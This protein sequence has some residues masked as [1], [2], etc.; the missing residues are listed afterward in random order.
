MLLDYTQRGDVLSLSYWG[1]DGMTHIKDIRLGSEELFNWKVC[2]ENDPEKDPVYRCWDGSPVKRTDYPRKTKDRLGNDK[3]LLPRLSPFRLAEIIDDLPKDM[4]DEIFSYNIPR[5]IFVDIETAVEGEF[6]KPEEARQPITCI[7]FATQKKKVYVYAV[8]PLSAIEILG[9]QDRIDKHTESLGVHFDFVFKKFQDETSMLKYFLTRN[10]PC[11]PLMSGWN[12]ID[13]DWT[14]MYNRACKLGLEPKGAS[15]VG[16]L[17]GEKKIPLHVGVVDYMEC[18]KKWDTNVEQKENYKLDQAGHDVLGMRKVHYSGNLQDLYEENFPEYI[19]YNAIDCILVERLHDKLGVS[20]IG[21]TLAYIAHAQASRM[22][23]PVALTES[24]MARDYYKVKR[25]LPPKERSETNKKKYQGAYVKEPRVGYHRFCICNDFASLYPNIIRMLNLSPETFVTKVDEHD[26]EAKKYWLDKGYIVSESGCV[27][28]KEPGI[29]AT[30]VGRVYN[31]RKEYKKTSYVASMKS[32][33]LKE[34]AEDLSMDDAALLHAARTIMGDGSLEIKGDVRGWMMEESARQEAE[35]IKFHNWEQ[36]T[37]IFINS[38]YGGFGNAFMYFFNVDLAECITK[39]GKSAILYAEKSINKYFLEW[40]HK[41]RKTHEAMGITV[42]G[43]VVNDVTVY[44]D[45][46][47]VYSQLDE[48]ISTT[49]WGMGPDD[50]NWRVKF[51]KPGDADWRY[52]YF[53][54]KKSREYVIEYL[55]LDSDEIA[56]YELERVEGTPK[57]FALLLDEVFLAKY[58]EHIFDKYVQKYNGYNY[59]NFELESYADSGIWLAKKKYMQNIR[60]LD[61]IKRHESYDN[62]SK[63]KSKGVELIQAS[64]P[65][66]VRKSLNYLVKWIFGHDNFKMKDLIIEVKRIKREYMVADI[67]EIC[68]NKKCSNYWEYVMSDSKVLEMKSGTPIYVKGLALYNYLLN[69]S[70]Y[71]SKYGRLKDGMM[72]KFYHCDYE[73]CEMFAFEPGMYPVEFAP[74]VNREVMFRKTILDPL[75]RILD[76]IPNA[77]HLEPDLMLVSKLF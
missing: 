3:V 42:T 24:I 19:F 5:H 43:K 18:Y 20:T 30:L 57:D 29:L 22:F 14:Y 68:W 60:W 12:F 51:K 28:S 34:A 72:C 25:V 16:M 26:D 58:F 44:I 59:L 8:K 63:I 35:Y 36:G 55:K 6:P 65:S 66:F 15:P 53:C 32:F 70:G 64:S 37:K 4:Y 17:M 47:S 71:K 23:S 61:K 69:D 74:Q 41:D 39:Q 7:G 54:G 56:E 75:N 38:I 33:A 31:Q 46:D 62:L 10:V 76:V 13:F 27:F 48:V 1:S 67:E 73:G 11:F 50:P 21:F 52:R 45:T 40:W 9:I 2:G 49:D 77:S